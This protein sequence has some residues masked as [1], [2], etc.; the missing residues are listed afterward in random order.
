MECDLPPACPLCKGRANELSTILIG[1]MAG[2]TAE[3]LRIGTTVTIFREEDGTAQ[4]CRI[5]PP[6]ISRRFKIEGEWVYNDDGERIWAT[7][8][9]SEEKPCSGICLS[10]NAAV[11][12]KLCEE[13]E[14]A[15]LKVIE[16][17]A[18][19]RGRLRG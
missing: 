19:G 8:G 13:C 14:E 18:S 9:S 4:N 3:M 12:V 10:Q 5:Y 11:E 17:T 6:G 15:L 2:R 1:G 7:A 16:A